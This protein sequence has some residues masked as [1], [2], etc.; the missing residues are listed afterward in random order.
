MLRAT[1]RFRAITLLSHDRGLAGKV[2]ASESSHRP[3]KGT[4][5]VRET[6]H[7]VVA[8]H[9]RPRPSRCFRD[10]ET[11]EPSKKGKARTALHLLQ[12]S[13]WSLEC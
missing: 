5:L 10:A 6:R 8:L 11:L 13:V 9:P 3:E 12:S 2:T 7:A 1:R 4:G